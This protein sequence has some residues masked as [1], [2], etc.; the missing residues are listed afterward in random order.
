MKNL[1]IIALIGLIVLMWLLKPTEVLWF[2]ATCG[3]LTILAFFMGEDYEVL[4]GLMNRFMAIFTMVAIA[5][6]IKRHTEVEESQ[7]EQQRHLKSVV[8]KRT[9]GLKQ[10]VDQLDEIKIRLAES[11][12]LG[13]FG[14]LFR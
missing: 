9:E 10:V 8:D 7:V 11:E 2:S 1:Q 13:Y 5:M 14:R 3:F 12:E 6:L 4:G